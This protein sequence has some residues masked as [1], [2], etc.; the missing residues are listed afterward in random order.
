[1]I[2]F[3]F[4]IGMTQLSIGPEWLACGPEWPLWF[5]GVLDHDTAEADVALVVVV[6]RRVLL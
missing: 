2:Q 5:A 1:M 4:V 3:A 6:A